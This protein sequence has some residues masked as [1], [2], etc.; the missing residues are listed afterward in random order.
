MSLKSFYSNGTAIS[1]TEHRYIFLL[2][3]LYNMFSTVMFCYISKTLSLLCFE[4]KHSIIV[5]WL[6]FDIQKSQFSMGLKVI[7]FYIIIR[8]TPLHPMKQQHWQHTSCPRRLMLI[9]LFCLSKL[10]CWDGTTYTFE[11]SLCYSKQYYKY[12]RYLR[13]HYWSNNSKKKYNLQNHL[14]CIFDVHPDT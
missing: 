4:L 14:Q 9:L 12:S 1:L 2:T 7:W 10:D 8:K 11:S 6:H 13:V 3:T 5:V